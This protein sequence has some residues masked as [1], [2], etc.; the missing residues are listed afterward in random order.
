M[1]GMEKLT[2][3]YPFARQLRRHPGVASRFVP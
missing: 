2:K 1:D 3:L